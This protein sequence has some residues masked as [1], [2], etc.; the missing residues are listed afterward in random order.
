MNRRQ[1]Y[2]DGNRITPDYL[3]LVVSIEPG[4]KEDE[5]ESQGGR[6]AQKGKEVVYC[7]YVEDCARFLLFTVRPAID[8]LI[9]C[10]P[11]CCGS[12]SDASRL[13]LRRQYGLRLV[14]RYILY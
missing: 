2:Q 4:R 3:I 8:L 7:L 10:F 13:A 9:F 5:S 12:A 1:I 6:L 14:M 11:G